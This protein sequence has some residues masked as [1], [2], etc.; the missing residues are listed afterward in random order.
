VV[1]GV[2]TVDAALDVRTWDA[3]MEA[4]TGIDAVQA[5]GRRLAELVPD[6][7]S[8]GL[9]ARFEQVLATGEVLLLAPAFHQYLIPCRPRTPSKHFDNM[10]QR[11]TLGAL[12]EGSRIVGVMATVEDVTARLDTERELLAALRSSDAA[13][14][15]DASR[16]LAAA[17]R[18]EL[19]HDFTSVL[20]DVNW[21]TR[22]AAVAGLTRHV[23]RGM[24]ASLLTALRDEHRDFN[25]LSSALQ[26]LAA[27]ELDV[28]A[29]LIELLR[30]GEVDLRIQ[31][32]LAL[33]EQ[34]HVS[35]I[36][37]LIQALTDPDVNVRYHAI[38]ALGRL[39][40]AEAVDP[41]GD[42]AES[43]DFFLAFP[44]L[45][46]LA[47]IHDS[48]VAPR[49]IAL[50]GQPELRE[51]AAEALGELGG[52]EVVAPL[53]G[54]LNEREPALPA[55]RALARI[56]ARYE[57]RYGAG[58]YVAAEFE[59]ALEP[60]GAQRVI[61]A[62]ADASL[63][64][65]RALIT[66]L[67]WL[68]GPAVERALTRLLGQSAYRPELVEVIARQDA[69]IVDLLIEQ[70]DSEDADTRMAAIMALG[71]V[72]DRRATPALARQ[73]ERDRATIVAAAGA[74]AAIADAAAF[75]PLLALLTHPDAS[76]RQAA[77]GALNSIGHPDMAGRIRPLLDAEDP[78]ARESAVRIAGYF[79][80]RDSI[81]RLLALCADPAEGVRRAAAEQLPFIDDPRALAQLASIV[82][83]DTPRVRAA[84]AQALGTV[85][86]GE[87]RRLLLDA[88][89]DQDPWVRYFAAR[90]LG[91]Q[92]DTGALTAL[93]DAARQDPAMHVRIAAVEAMSTIAAAEATDALLLYATDP[94]VELAAAALTGLGASADPRALD[95]LRAA[96]RSDE[97]AHRL[98]AVQG[99]T[100]RAAVDAIELLAWTAG[101][102]TDARV[103]TSAMAALGKLARA[104]DAA[105][106]AALDAL[107]SITSERRFR[108]AAIGVLGALPDRRMP[109]VAAA[110]RHPHPEVRQS[111]IAAL[112]RMKHPDVSA[113]L[114]GALGD[115][116]ADVRE[117]AIVALDRLGARGVARTFA[118]M[119]RQ[120]P[121][122]V[123]RRAAAAALS[124]TAD[125]ARD[126]GQA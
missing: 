80:Y 34:P 14:R 54:W 75:D 83:T 36:E 115:G 126:R 119:A 51:P 70:L 71:R 106:D 5:H 86:G 26:L 35:A 111:V 108:D 29:P 21:M 81:E 59:A 102:D 96:L 23:D 33:G 22:R 63:E 32:A 105:G 120:D 7:A 85:T 18:L 49:L 43:G 40:A 90:A 8:R 64:D 62:T 100:I 89:A 109:S 4:A 25:V 97:P 66:L 93:T 118:E 68:R 116:D 39:R 41:L 107:V 103:A 121:S 69:G 88:I 61:E 60:A 19:P 77:I 112:G 31:A 10:Q 114:R 3:W 16:Q 42:I 72:G 52:A 84:A 46:A 9:L 122:R 74:L 24:L 76:V 13:V 27:S 6:I 65:L 48:R 44:A 38:E 101:A 113:A 1:F 110:L 30:T 104:A 55:V 123:V 20:R 47:Q 56:H 117:A 50:L 87:V 53:V 2:F 79:G 82:R 94:H 17:E 37:A 12:R 67:G 58:V 99:L 15:E 98:A 57:E 124:R 91:Q 125:P 92:R 78:V 11:V 73:L 28:T 45:D 95:S